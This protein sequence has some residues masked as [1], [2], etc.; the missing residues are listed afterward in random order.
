MK[1]VVKEN[2]PQAAFI[3]HFSHW[4]DW[5]CMLYARFIIEEPSQAPNE[6]VALYNRIWDMAIRAAIREGGVI[7]E[8]HGVGLKLGRIMRD[9]Y[10]PAFNVLESLKKVLDPN[11]IMNPGKM[12]FPGKGV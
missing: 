9:L 2:F 5:G 8:H 10:G 4:Y 3:G 7:N 1:N 11:N 12:G 6:A